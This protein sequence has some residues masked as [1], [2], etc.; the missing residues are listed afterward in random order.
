M[1]L[2]LITLSLI[3]LV[4]CDSGSPTRN[5]KQSGPANVESGKTYRET[6]L[7]GV[8]LVDATE[9]ATSALRTYG[10][11]YALIAELLSDKPLQFSLTT[12]DLDPR[13]LSP[14]QDRGEETYQYF[15]RLTQSDNE[16]VREWYIK[17]NCSTSD[18]I[19]LS[20]ALEMKPNERLA[21]FIG[22]WSWVTTQPLSSTG[23]R[24]TSR[25]R[26]LLF[27]VFYHLALRI[28]SELRFR[29]SGRVLQEGPRNS[30]HQS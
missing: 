7:E 4:G 17:V 9:E 24:V 23:T 27:L 19:T 13:F 30:D 26:L 2:L 5:A 10:V 12:G 18:Q 25:L 14:G 3:G 29:Q 6:G 11:Q 15:V 28:P 16:S 20:N 1:R 22:G 21:G 8:Y